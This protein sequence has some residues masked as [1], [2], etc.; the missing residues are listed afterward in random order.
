[1]HTFRL[2][3]HFLLHWIQSAFASCWAETLFSGFVTIKRWKLN[4]HWAGF[5]HF[6]ACRSGTLAA[7]AICCS[8]EYCCEKKK[9]AHIGAAIDNTTSDRNINEKDTVTRKCCERLHQCLWSIGVNTTFDWPKLTLIHLWAVWSTGHMVQL[10]T[11]SDHM[12][13]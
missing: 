3:F 2:P 9:K 10:L 7:Q 4:K 13:L 11:S 6:Q 12:T 5:T 1:M 8:N